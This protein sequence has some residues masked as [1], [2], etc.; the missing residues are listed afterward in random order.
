[1]V[2]FIPLSLSKFLHPERAFDPLAE[3]TKPRLGHNKTAARRL[4]ESCSIALRITAGA[5]MVTKLETELKREF[6]IGGNT[7]VLTITPTELKLTLKGRRKGHELAWNDFISGDAALAV[8]LNASLAK[9]ASVKTPAA[10]RV[11]ATE[12]ASQQPLRQAEP[13]TMPMAKAMKKAAK[14][15]RSRP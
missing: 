14:K 3:P 4:F 12:P 13:A 1:M 9:A 5:P 2:Q 6:D 10:T 15:S 11:P 7:Y 8:A